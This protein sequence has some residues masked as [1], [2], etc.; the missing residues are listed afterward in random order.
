MRLSILGLAAIH[1]LLCAC[2]ATPSM[3]TTA[4]RLATLLPTAVLLLGEQHDAP[5]H[6]VI[7]REVV[8]TLAERKALAAVAMEMAPAGTST[9]GLPANA[10]EAQVQTALQWSDAA[11]PWAAYGPVVMAAVRAG[12]PVHGANLPQTQMRPAM[13]N[14][15]L[16]A[17]LRGPAIKAQQQRIRQGHCDLLPESQ[18][19]PMTRIQIA[20]DQQMAQTLQTLAAQAD[21]AA[22]AQAG[23]ASSQTVLLIAGAGHVDRFAGVPQHFEPDLKVKVLIAS[24]DRSSD[25]MNLEA[26][27]IWSTPAL[28]PKDYCAAFKPR[29]QPTK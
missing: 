8:Q 14:T 3:P 23:G 10:T 19:Q 18:I 4:E 26:D 20:R 27:A 11:W 25:A 29:V 16:D 9:L 28:P 13:Q 1:A 24:A 17:A 2:A 6:Q 12:V 15:Q 22:R 7:E 21:Q 5:Q